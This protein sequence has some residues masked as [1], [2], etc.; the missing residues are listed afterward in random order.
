MLHLPLPHLH[1][2]LPALVQVVAHSPY[3]VQLLGARIP[4]LPPHALDVHRHCTVGQ[5]RGA[6]DR[7]LADPTVAERLQLQLRVGLARLPHQRDELRHHAAHEQAGPRQHLAH[8]LPRDPHLRGLRALDARGGPARRGAAGLLRRGHAGRAE[9]RVCPGP[10]LEA[11]G[12]VF[13][14]SQVLHHRLCLLAVPQ[15]HR[16][17]R[18]RRPVDPHVAAGGRGC[19]RGRRVD[20]RAARRAVRRHRGRLRMAMQRGS[21]HGYRRTV[22]QERSYR[23]ERVGQDPRHEAEIGERYSEGLHGRELHRLRDL[24]GG[25]VCMALPQLCQAGAAH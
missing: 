13:H 15:G 4:G 12:V 2:G 9:V 18:R 6:A 22:Q 10:L 5:Q 8:R 17:R 11:D 20:E 23:S 14:R 16:G 3:A 7:N 24:Y 1:G 19:G 21:A 25:H